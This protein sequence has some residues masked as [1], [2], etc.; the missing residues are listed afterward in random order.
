MNAPYFV[1]SDIRHLFA[2]KIRTTTKDPRKKVFCLFL[3]QKQDVLEPING[4]QSIKRDTNIFVL[5]DILS[6]TFLVFCVHVFTK[7]KDNPQ[8]N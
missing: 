8:P 2:S 6:A 4:G 5:N 1:G 3:V 7:Q